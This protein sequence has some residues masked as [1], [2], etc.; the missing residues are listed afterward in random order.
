MREVKKVAAETDRSLTGVIEDALR[1]H[2]SRR[3]EA[4]SSPRL[5]LPVDGEGGLQP[6]VSIDDSR[7]LRELLDEGRALDELR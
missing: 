5:A 4:V 3:R 6:G 7:A 2:L 1:E